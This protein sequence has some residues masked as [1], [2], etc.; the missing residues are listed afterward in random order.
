M[1][2]VSTVVRRVAELVGTG[3]VQRVEILRGVVTGRERREVEQQVAR[4]DIASCASFD[5]AP[6]Q[7][8]LTVANI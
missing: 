1:N 3:Q 5:P 8:R 2:H 4:F 7:A 6:E